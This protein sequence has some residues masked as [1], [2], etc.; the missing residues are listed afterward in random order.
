MNLLSC[1]LLIVEPVGMSQIHSMSTELSIAMSHHP[2]CNTMGAVRDGSV[3]RF[4]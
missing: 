4:M 3:N 1:T 2:V